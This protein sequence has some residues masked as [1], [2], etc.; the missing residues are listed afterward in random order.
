MT[1]TTH[2]LNP[3]DFRA[4]LGHFA[5]GVVAI[6]AVD[7]AT[8]RPTG[9]AANSFTSVSLDPPLVAFC[10]AHT[11][12][13]WPLLKAAGT[14]V[15]NV[16]AAEQEHVCRQLAVKGGDKFAGLEWEP[17]PGGAPI[18]AE[19][20]AWLEA[21]VAAEHPAGDHTIVVANVRHIYASERTPLLFFRGAY[22]GISG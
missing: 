17:S 13:T 20:L 8:G 10:V 16:L 6:T 2:E 14:F 19:G 12:S 4:V 22:G 9:L 15:V 3:A 11:S 18:L 21:D 1:E 7:P 5:T